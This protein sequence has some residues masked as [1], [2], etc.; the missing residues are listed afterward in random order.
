MKAVSFFCEEH[1]I[2]I[3]NL[4]DIGMTNLEEARKAIKQEPDKLEYW[5]NQAREL[6]PSDM[7]NTVRELHNKPPLVPKQQTRTVSLNFTS[8]KEW[9]KGQKCLECSAPATPHHW[10]RTDKMGG[11][12]MVPLCDKHHRIA[13][14][15]GPLT[16]FASNNT[17]KVMA[18]YLDKIGEILDKKEGEEK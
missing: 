12:F 13:Q 5:I 14:D 7:I 9:V 16:W 18:N 2:P 17:W 3:D 10:P 6:S 1:K 15:M 4:L 8:F 11:K